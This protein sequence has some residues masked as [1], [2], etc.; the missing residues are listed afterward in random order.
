MF[1]CVVT[2]VTGS[3]H[4]SEPTRPDKVNA[5]TVKPSK[6]ETSK[7]A[8]PGWTG[9]KLVTGASN[10]NGRTLLKIKMTGSASE[11]ERMEFPGVKLTKWGEQ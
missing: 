6:R 1:G 3:R 10:G 4:H 9:A 2:F 7:E 8:S 5:C 11:R